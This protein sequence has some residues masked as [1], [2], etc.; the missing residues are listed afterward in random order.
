MSAARP[1]A[2]PAPR[3][4]AFSLFRL[5][6]VTAGASR[7]SGLPGYNST[8]RLTRI[9]LTH[10]DSTSP[11]PCWSFSSIGAEIAPLGSTDTN[12]S[13]GSIRSPKAAPTPRQPAV[14]PTRPPQPHRKS[15]HPPTI[16]H[17]PTGSARPE[18]AALRLRSASGSPRGPEMTLT[19]SCRRRRRRSHRHHRRLHRLRPLR[20]T[21]A[22]TTTHHHHLRRAHRRRHSL[23]PASS[24]RQTAVDATDDRTRSCMSKPAPPQARE[25]E[26][27]PLR[28]PAHTLHRSAPQ[29][30]PC[31]PRTRTCTRTTLP[32]ARATRALSGPR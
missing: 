12:Q 24:G 16:P 15:N 18:K 3:H 11:P 25:P 9:P 13:D 20:R 21:T 5:L 26:G 8:R 30:A 7:D 6:A 22:T 1:A 10:M 32:Q 28:A 23:P 29:I 31:E 19:V 27:K 4:L 2:P 14:H 17:A